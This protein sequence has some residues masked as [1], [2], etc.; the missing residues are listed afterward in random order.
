MNW[1]TRYRWRLYTE[2]DKI[3]PGD[4]VLLTAEQDITW[5]RGN[6]G[7]EFEVIEEITGQVKV[8]VY[9]R[10]YNIGTFSRYARDRGHEICHINKGDF[11]IK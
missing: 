1:E 7:V 8:K 6:K 11:M 4:I 9:E 10:N 2:G 5:Y 3:T